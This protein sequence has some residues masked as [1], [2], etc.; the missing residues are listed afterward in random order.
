MC[1]WYSGNDVNVLMPFNAILV[2]FKEKKNKGKES[3]QIEI[4]FLKVLKFA[5]LMVWDLAENKN[6]TPLSQ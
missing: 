6:I 2:L 4:I 5:N 1:V 3:S